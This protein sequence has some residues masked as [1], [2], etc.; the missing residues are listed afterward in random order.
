MSELE[1]QRTTSR[2]EYN[3]NPDFGNYA[4]LAGDNPAILNSAIMQNADG[5]TRPIAVPA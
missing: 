5:N 4:T 3:Y 1:S 2:A